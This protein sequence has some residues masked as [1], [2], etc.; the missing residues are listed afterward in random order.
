MDSFEKGIKAGTIP[1]KE[2]SER[3]IDSKNAMPV[4]TLYEFERNSRSSF[5]GILSTARGTETTMTPERNMLQRRLQTNIDN[6]KLVRGSVA[7]TFIEMYLTGVYM[8]ASAV[9]HYCSIIGI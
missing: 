9:G 8:H 1:S 4:R 3:F 6:I 7:K 5:H 2:Y